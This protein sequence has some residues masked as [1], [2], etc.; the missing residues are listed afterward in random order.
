MGAKKYKNSEWSD[1]CIVSTPNDFV[2]D[3]FGSYYLVKDP[4]ECVVVCATDSPTETPDP[5]EVVKKKEEEK[6][7]GC[8]R[9]G[10]CKGKHG[11]CDCTIKTVDE[12]V[13]TGVNSAM[14]S[15][16]CAPICIKNKEEGISGCYRG[17]ICDGSH[18]C[19]DCEMTEQE[20]TDEDKT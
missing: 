3:S 10:A 9:G 19:C 17:G 16:G 8:Y 2:Y 11:C 7:T 13:D 15:T 4:S 12:C 20:C 14:I 18:G 6:V 1:K 5:N